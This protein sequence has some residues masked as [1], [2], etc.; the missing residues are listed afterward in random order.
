M[1]G[2]THTWWIVFEDRIGLYLGEI[3]VRGGSRNDARCEGHKTAL[4]DYPQAHRMILHKG[5]R[6][7]Q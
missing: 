4:R 2:T 5:V 3:T 6:M 1:A 7:R